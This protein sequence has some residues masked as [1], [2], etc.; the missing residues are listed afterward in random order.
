[1]T[2]F[3]AKLN[4][5]IKLIKMCLNGKSNEVCVRKYL[6]V[7]FPIQKGLKQEYAL[8]PLHFN[9][10]LEYHL[11]NVQ[12]NQVPLQLHGTSELLA[13]V[14]DFLPSHMLSKN[15]KVGI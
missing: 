6:S 1:M 10:A 4:I 7:N 8:S 13:S 9:V 15:V 12:K 5:F 14:Q 2:Y 3:K 11:R